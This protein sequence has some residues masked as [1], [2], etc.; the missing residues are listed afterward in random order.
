MNDTAVERLLEVLRPDED[1]GIDKLY[2][3]AKGRFDIPLPS[4]RVQMQYVGAFVTRINA[5]IKG[6]KKR[7]EPGVTRRTYRLNTNVAD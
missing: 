1:V 3:A 6:E 2:Q 7:I 4:S 5:R